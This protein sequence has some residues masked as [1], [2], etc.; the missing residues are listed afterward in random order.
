MKK[1][2][3]I[4]IAIILFALIVISAMA[5]LNKKTDSPGKMETDNKN[6][7]SDLTGG[8][9]SD[10]KIITFA[11]PDIC[12]IDDDNL[13]H[14]NDELIKDG[15]D[16]LLKIK[17][18]EYN[19]YV[20]LLEGELKTGDTD[21]AFLG[22]GDAS[23]NNNIYTLINSGLI[24]NLDEILSQESGAVLYNAFPQKLWESVKCDKH[25]Y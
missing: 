21:I 3:I 20:Q 14:F 13:Q 10:A 23:G 18:L 19:E 4:L 1:N 15:H 7:T 2:R 6:I 5:I 22:L 25:I 17:Y 8:E 12:K 9:K 11:V 16:Y 24:L